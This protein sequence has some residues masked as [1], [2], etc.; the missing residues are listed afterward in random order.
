MKMKQI[1]RLSVLILALFAIVANLGLLQILA[2]NMTAPKLKLDESFSWRNGSY[3]RIFYGESDAQFIDLYVPA[4]TVNPRLFVLVHGGGFVMND[5]QS[6]QAQFMYRFFREKGYACASVNYRLADEAPFPAACDDVHNAVVF[7][8]QNAQKY[9]YDAS[10]IAIWGESA[11]G[12]LATREALTETDAPITALVSYYGCYELA[13]MGAQFEQQG[14]S[15]FIRTVSSFWTA[16]KLNG[17]SSCEEFW[18]RKAYKDW[19]DEDRNAASVL[20]IAE[21]GPAN[22]SLDVMLVHG[23]ADI[24][25]PMQQSVNLAEA[26][27]AFYGSEHVNFI[28]VENC[29]HADDRLYSDEILTTVES[30]LHS[31]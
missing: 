6:R 31:R 18:M 7:L 10:N 19:T 14:I 29:I 30:F 5:A 4:D 22:R 25:V 3:E 8:S 23:T 28:T 9:G 26:L 21:R 11:G 27:R 15:R 20:A 12:Y 2:C 24:T 16:G 1:V 13:V 17:Y